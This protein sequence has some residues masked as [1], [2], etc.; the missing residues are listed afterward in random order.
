MLV[1]KRRRDES[2]II[3]EDIVVTVIDIRGDV[4]RLGIAAPLDVEVDR[5]EVRD[6]KYSERARE[7]R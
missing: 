3:G 1:L 6:R 4:V 5:S 2:I 7:D